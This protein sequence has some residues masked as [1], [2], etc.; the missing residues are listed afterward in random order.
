[1][2]IRADGRAAGPRARA[3]E[4]L[5]PVEYHRHTM[6]I[7]EGTGQIRQ[8]VTSRATSGLGIE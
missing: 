8:L 4:V 2:T 3:F 1:M 5:G 7:F 6:D